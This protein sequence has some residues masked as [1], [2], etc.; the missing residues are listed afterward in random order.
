MHEGD[1]MRY[2]PFGL[3]YDDIDIY[4]A[5]NTANSKLGELNGI[6]NTMP[7]VDKEGSLLINE[8]MTPAEIHS[9]V[10]KLEEK[11]F[12]PTNYGENAFDGFEVA[13]P[14]EMFSD[15]A[16]E[17]LHK[18]VF[19]KGELICKAIGTFD[20]RIIENDVKVRFPW[21]PKTD[22][23][24]EVNYYLQF[25]EALCKMAIDRNRV[26]STAKKSENEKY[27]FRCFLLRL[28]FI[29]DEYKG[30]RKFLMRNLSGNAAFKHGKLKE[31]LISF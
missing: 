6:I 31:E 10:A 20:L 7:N 2:L 1:N 21:Y 4:K 28:G 18:I 23:S 30:L 26:T 16:L 24:G 14:R 8:S 9:L 17:N 29:G 11:G 22:D 25:T 3:N 27:D 12:I 13:M 5:L 15:K 19:A